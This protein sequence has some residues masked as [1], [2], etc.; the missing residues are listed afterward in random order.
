[1]SPPVVTGQK[2]GVDGSPRSVRTP[3]IERNTHKEGKFCSERG[4]R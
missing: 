1:M 4:R 2:A 3:A